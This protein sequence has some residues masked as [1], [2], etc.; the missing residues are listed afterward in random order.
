MEMYLFCEMCEWQMSEM[1]AFL[2]ECPESDMYAATVFSRVVF[3]YK[4]K[5]PSE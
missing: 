1:I 2:D 4:Q 5:L 3:F